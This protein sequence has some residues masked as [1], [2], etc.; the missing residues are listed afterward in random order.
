M[1]KVSTT[2]SHHQPRP[3]RDA[4][5]ARIREQ[6]MASRAEP[7]GADEQRDLQR[8]REQRKLARDLY[9][10]LAKHWGSLVLVRLGAAEQAHLNALD[11]LLDHY[12]LSDP[13]A[14]PAVGESGDPKFHALHAQ[15]VEVGHRSEMAASQ[16]GLLVEEMS[17]SDLA[18][19]RA[20]TR[21]PE[22]AAALERFV[23][24]ELYTDGADGDSQRNQRLQESRF[25]TVAIP[26]YA[27]VSPD[28][29]V[30]ATFAGLTRDASQFL[31]FLRVA[32]S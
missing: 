9:W 8:I 20:R 19:A 15:I 26:F 18:A 24:L 3:G 16:A 4:H 32:G 7:L 2:R 25:G 1:A 12:D 23:L 30:I 17:L 21:R 11:T 28:E 29:K 13:V 22:I 10:D 5:L 27:I 31:R 14:G 6:I